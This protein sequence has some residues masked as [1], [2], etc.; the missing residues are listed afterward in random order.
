MDTQPQETKSQHRKVIDFC[1]IDTLPTRDDFIDAKLNKRD[2]KL[3]AAGEPIL[4]LP[5]PMHQTSL[6]DQES[7]GKDNKAYYVLILFGTSESGKRMTVVIE[8]FRPYFMVR[9]PDSDIDKPDEF[10]ELLLTKLNSTKDTKALG[11]R[12]EYY[13]RYKGYEENK[14]PYVIIE[15]AKLRNRNKAIDVVRRDLNYETASDDFSAEAY[16]RVVSRDTNI[17][18]TQWLEISNYQ[19]TED[20]NFYE[21]VFKVDYRNVKTYQGPMDRISLIKDPT[22]TA[23]FDL[24]TYDRKHRVPLPEFKESNIFNIG[25]VFCRAN[26]NDSLIRYLISTRVTASREG[27]IT[28]LCE[29]EGQ[30]IHTFAKL[31]S[32]MRPELLGA[33][34]C[35]KYDWPWIITRAKDYEI[36]DV[37][38]NEV[39][40]MRPYK[41]TSAEEIIKWNCR[42]EQIKIEA[43]FNAQELLVKIPGLQCFDVQTMFR[44]LFPTEGQ[45]SLEFFL[46]KCKL[47]GKMDMTARTMFIAHESMEAFQTH[48]LYKDMLRYEKKNNMKPQDEEY[49]NS[50]V[51]AQAVQYK[52]LLG[53][54]IPEKEMDIDMDMN[55]NEK[56]TE[57]IKLYAKYTEAKKLMAEIAEYCVYDCYRCHQLMLRRGVISA[58]RM[59]S[60]ISHTSLFDSLYRAGGCKTRNL[61]IKVAKERGYAASNIST[62]IKTNTKVPGAYV[63]HPIPGVRTT[64][65]TPEERQ[66]KNK[67]WQEDKEKHP[68]KYI[69]SSIEERQ[70]LPYPEF[71]KVTEKQI[72]ALKDYVR[73]HQEINPVKMPEDKAREL[74][75]AVS[76]ANPDIPKLGKAFVKYLME[77][78]DRPLTALDFSSLYPSI[79]MA[80]N[81]S[82][83]MMITSETHGGL[84][85]A[86]ELSKKLH[87]AGHQLHRIEFMYGNTPVLAWCIRHENKKEKMGVFP[88]VYVNLFALRKKY[89]VP[90]EMHE[91]IDEYMTT[92]GM[93]SISLFQ[94]FVLI[95]GR[96]TKP[97]DYNLFDVRSTLAALELYP[98]E[99]FISSLITRVNEFQLPQGEEL[100]VFLGKKE[101]KLSQ[102]YE[103]KIANSPS[104]ITLPL[105]E[106]RFYYG[107][108]HR[109]QE[110]VKV[111]MNTFYGESGNQLSALYMKEIAGAVTSGGQYNLRLAKSIVEEQKCTVHYGDTDSL[112]ISAKED[113][114]REVD[115]LYFCGD[116]TKLEYWER[117]IRIAF[118]EI[119]K[120]RDIVN[121]RL[122]KDNGTKYLKMAYEEVLWPYLLQRKKKYGGVKHKEMINFEIDSIFKLFL[123]GIDAKRR[124]ISPL[125]IT[126]TE[127]IM[128]TIFK[129]SNLWTL[130]ELA[131]AEIDRIYTSFYEGKTKTSDFVKSAKY[132]PISAEDRLAGKGNRSMCTF[133]DRM[134]ARGTPLAPYTR[135]SYVIAKKYPFKYDHKGRKQKLSTGE[136]M[137][138]L[139]YVQSNGL[140]IDIDYYV[141]NFICGQLCPF[142]SYHPDFYVA[143]VDDTPE[144]TK[145]AGELSNKNARKFLSEYCKIYIKKYDDRG[146]IMKL[147]SSYISEILKD[148]YDTALESISEKHPDVGELQVYKLLNQD[149]NVGTTV[150]FQKSVIKVGEAIAEKKTKSDFY[151]E[152]AVTFVK[153]LI[154]NHGKDYIY[155]LHSQFI[156]Q[157]QSRVRVAAQKYNETRTKIMNVL[158]T[159]INT[160]MS[161]IHKHIAITEKYIS[162]IRDKCGINR[163][164]DSPDSKIPKAKSI[165]KLLK[166][167][168]PDQDSDE[169]EAILNSIRVEMSDVI[170]EFLGDKYYRRGLRALAKALD[171]IEEAK[172]EY[173]KIENIA[174]Y[175]KERID[176]DNGTNEP[177][178]DELNEMLSIISD[179]IDNDGK[180][181]PPKKKKSKKVITDEYRSAIIIKEHGKD[182]DSDSEPDADWE[183]QQEEENNEMDV[184]DEDAALPIDTDM[185]ED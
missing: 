73:E 34:N 181:I 84:G 94:M 163:L 103:F 105:E 82:Q 138:T 77:N 70:G 16:H 154:K 6:W 35:G 27:Y 107:H 95:K 180:D 18:L 4:F 65:F 78:T 20:T 110:Q 132:Q 124:G 99:Q 101:G 51:R 183:A 112:Y 174:N 21:N 42:H 36:L 32:R 91:F 11:V 153:R 90:M 75:T 3:I 79:V 122:E 26:E 164:L 117:M 60:H 150:K 61:L 54:D 146:P 136:R 64:R 162:V 33:F 19:Y 10:S 53:D 83:E 143:P 87:K 157:T 81:L 172:I 40:S 158:G 14:R 31:L 144:D 67:L 39:S 168:N 41:E 50:V 92:R 108:F 38:Y 13:K 72:K 56:Y 125:S 177:S 25:V 167:A 135:I 52:F 161:T 98:D 15:F 1:A 175:V 93:D 173:T 29:N 133:A 37:F 151:K 179:K 62:G 68:E 126:A 104:E 12:V 130:R 119:D 152:H 69:D 137:E 148:A 170:K 123:R 7:K 128:L 141:L 116:I 121:A 88:S 55:E 184:E 66:E 178:T 165:N 102:Q 48:P 114:F 185:I 156:T 129:P 45:W 43:G 169:I 76:D 176:R 46:N 118:E 44:Q 17:S 63:V 147:I 57:I 2:E 160:V 96:F 171:N 28:I 59:M 30:A 109:R 166:I 149:W 115:R 58:R 145:K 155:L 106:V 182:G 85:G 97:E 47:K 89:K 8:N 80:Y 113:V 86:L 100:D 71:V 49:S 111:F 22:M 127:N 159:R 139:E 134:Q 5:A 74:V 24:E 131:L 120:L 142:I 140:Q 23:Y 9:I